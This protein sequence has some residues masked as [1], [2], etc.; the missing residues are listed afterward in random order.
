MPSDPEVQ[1]ALAALASR[2]QQ[3]PLEEMNESQFDGLLFRSADSVAATTGWRLRYHTYRSRN[4]EPGF[5]DRVLVRERVIFVETKAMETPTRARKP[6]ALQVEWLD[7]LARAGGEVYL[8]NPLDF[9]EAGLV[10]GRRWAFSPWRK[11][12]DCP[13]LV[14]DLKDW[15]PRSMW[16]PGVGRAD[17]HPNYAAFAGSPKA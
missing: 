11:D 2:R 5:V 16:I 17:A 1:Q 3:I 4:S 10:L 12:G 13:T 14:R 6:T 7:G 15:T 8:W 9:D